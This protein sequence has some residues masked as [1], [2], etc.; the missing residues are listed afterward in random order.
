[1]EKESNEIWLACCSQASVPHST[2]RVH[3]LG[4][5][6]H[7]GDGK[8]SIVRVTSSYCYATISSKCTMN[9]QYKYQIN[10]SDSDYLWE[11]IINVQEEGREVEG[12]TAFCP[13]TVQKIPSEAFARHARIIYVGSIYFTSAW[14]PISL[15]YFF[16]WNKTLLC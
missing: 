4:M 11:P 6:Y 14:A 12:L 2:V 15:K 16:V 13:S 8:I 1:M 10:F 3:Q 5:R 9:L 7:F